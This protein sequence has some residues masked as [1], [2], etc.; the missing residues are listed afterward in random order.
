MLT[1]IIRRAVGALLVTFALIPGVVIL[2]A[3]HG[4]NAECAATSCESGTGCYSQG[5]CLDGQRCKLDGDTPTWVDDSSCNKEEY[6]V[7]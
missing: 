6:V 1:N 3:E 4:L 2:T 5:K 7:E